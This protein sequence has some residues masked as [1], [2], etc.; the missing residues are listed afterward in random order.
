VISVAGSSA[1]TFGIAGRITVRL[2]STPLR[3]IL[4]AVHKPIRP[5]RLIVALLPI[6]PIYPASIL[7]A[8]GL[9][10]SDQAP[11]TSISETLATL[12]ITKAFLRRATLAGCGQ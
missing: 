8:T 11:V 10:G 4:A 2:P 9:H 12:A 7:H 1:D 6:T 3:D 5:I